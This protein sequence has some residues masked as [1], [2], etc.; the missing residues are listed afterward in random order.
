MIYG[1]YTEENA[2]SFIEEATPLLN[3]LEELSCK[4]G[5]CFTKILITSVGNFY[6]TLESDTSMKKYKEYLGNHFFKRLENI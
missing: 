2:I 1:D 5:I 4:H 3:K 6:V